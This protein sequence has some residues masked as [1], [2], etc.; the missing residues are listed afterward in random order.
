MT[1]ASDFSKLKLLGSPFV[2]F[3]QHAMEGEAKQRKEVIHAR[4]SMGNDCH[5]VHSNQKSSQMFLAF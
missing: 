5:P 4:L 3:G 1:D 2:F